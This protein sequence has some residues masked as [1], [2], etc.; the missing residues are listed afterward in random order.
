VTA[1]LEGDAIRLST[2]RRIA[3]T[4]GAVQGA[5]D[6]VA[7]A[8]GVLRLT[9]WALGRRERRPADA[10]FVM[11]GRRCL[12]VVSP[13]I[14]RGDLAADFGKEANA[15]GFSFEIPVA[16]AESLA[17]SPDLRLFGAVGNRAT[18]LPAP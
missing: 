14:Q 12:G 3:L 4:P 5:R 13:N 7:A 11:R 9:G 16:D 15:S 8:A 1:R 17:A 18:E 6:Q 2:G 10:V